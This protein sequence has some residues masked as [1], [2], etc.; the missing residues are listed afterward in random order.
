MRNTN[1]P[2]MM[3]IPVPFQ[4]EGLCAVIRDN[5]NKLCQHFQTYTVGQDYPVSRIHI[6]KMYDEDNNMQKHELFEMNYSNWKNDGSPE[7]ELLITDS[8]VSKYIVCAD[9][10]TCFP[11]V[12]SHSL[13]WA[14]VGKE[15]AKSNRDTRLWFNKIDKACQSIKNGET[16]GLLIGPHASNLL[17]E[18]ILVVVDKKLWDRGYRFYRNIDDYDCYVASY[19]DAQKFLNALEYELRQF[20]LIINYKKTRID[21]L[22]VSSTEHWIHKLNA[23]STVA[24]YGKTSYKEV[25]NYIDIAIKL[26]EETS[27]AAILK[28]AIKTLAGL[29]NITIN[30]NNI[31]LKRIMHLTIIYPYLLP[32]MQ[33]YVFDRYGICPVEIIKFAN[34]LYCESL[35]INNYE[36]VCFAI[37]FSLVYEFDIS[38]INCQELINTQDCL[39]MLFAW[40]YFRRHGTD[41]VLCLL[42]REAERLRD[43]SMGRYWLFVYEVL[44]ANELK[45]DWKTMKGKNISFIRRRFSV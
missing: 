40:I 33:P 30:G 10:S 29:D 35:R 5:W 19:E 32:L 41:K 7:N 12:Y 39:V 9:I 14:L 24:S 26:T 15:Y 17:A 25:N 18:I 27:N 34:I 11:S 8:G 22:P 4:Y 44:S 37:Y 2:R 43:T 31:A 42:K 36:G 16:H 3:G 23:I 1:I 45:D 38:N 21:E 6:R 13:P 28:Y 20:D